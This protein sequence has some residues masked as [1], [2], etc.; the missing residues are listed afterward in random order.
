M[1]RVVVV[2]LTLAGLILV[3]CGPAVMPAA[4]PEMANGENFVIALPR[5]V[6]SFDANGKP[7][8]EGL[9]VEQIARSLGFPLDLN[10][11]RIDPAYVNW[12][13]T[14]NIQHV[15]VRQT[16]GGLALLANGQLMP[17]IKWED[18]SLEATAGLVRMLGP[19]NEQLASV[20]QKLAPI[21][22]RL[23]LSIVLKFPLQAGAAAI[24]LAADSVVLATPVPVAGPASAVVQF[25][26]KY[27][28]DGVPSIMGISARDLAA[29]GI[30]APLA[31]HPYYVL[32]AQ[33]NN[34][35]YMQLRSKGDGLYVYL[36]GTSLPAIA[37]D[38][39]ALDNTLGLVQKLYAA[40][41]I[42]W[43][44]IKQFVPLLSN[45]DVSVLLSL[46]VA[47]GAEV[48]PIKRQ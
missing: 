35:Q 29:A 13:S 40:Y 31:L 47:S 41:P 25:E 32:Q 34:I 27:D 28:A 36:N 7:G 20:L 2:L 42:D 3:G 44:L 10:A 4:A 23:G 16:G 38:K 1:R 17:S 18:G 14:S 22:K 11:Y 48:I 43:E 8:V 24:P 15:E 46:P 5:L 9:P 26:I 30:N 39:T 33:L 6:L 21:A 12:M 19:Q 45:T 37:W